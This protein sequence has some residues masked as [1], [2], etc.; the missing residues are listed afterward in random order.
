MTVWDYLRLNFSSGLR[1]TIF[2]ARVRFDRSRSSKIIDFGANR[3]RAYD[4]LLV[5][6]KPWSYLAPFRRYFRFLCS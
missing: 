5:C 4:F 1:K 6:H 2:S 3:K